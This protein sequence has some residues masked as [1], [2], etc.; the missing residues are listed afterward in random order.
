MIGGH[1]QQPKTINPIMALISVVLVLALLVFLVKGI[2]TILYYAAPILIIASF[3]LDKSVII[4]YGKFLMNK[5]KTDTLMGIGAVALSAVA[6]PILSGYLFLKALAKNKIDKK[7]KEFEKR[8]Q[9]E[10][11]EYEEVEDDDFLDLPKLE[12]TV[13]MKSKG[14]KSSDNTYD[15]M[16]E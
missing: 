12:K 4:D 2:F 11:A 6:F 10:Y 7:I 13:E 3:V 9:G 15:D 1:H 16:F 5:L 8:E 14:T